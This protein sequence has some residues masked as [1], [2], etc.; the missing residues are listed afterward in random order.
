MSTT[1]SYGTWVN[2]GDGEIDLETNVVVALG[3][4]VDSFDLEGLAH[5]YREAINDNL[6]GTG[7]QMAGNEFYG[8][9]PA[10]V[11]DPSEVIAEAVQAVDF[12]TLA[13]RFDRG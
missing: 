4:F 8:P 10:T 2:H 12:W 5:A 6:S 3:D 13:E 11:A 7:I 1:T 9:V